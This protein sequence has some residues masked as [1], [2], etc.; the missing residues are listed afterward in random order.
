MDWQRQRDTIAR[1][2]KILYD[3]NQKNGGPQKEP[4]EDDTG[5]DKTYIYLK[6]KNPS[7]ELIILRQA[8]FSTCPLK[9]H[10]GTVNSLKISVNFFDTSSD[11]SPTNI[12][13][14]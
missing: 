3:R 1:V 12:Y 13:G 7:S 6:R 11:N 10:A 8:R 2:R 14:I 4:D 9:I 5:P